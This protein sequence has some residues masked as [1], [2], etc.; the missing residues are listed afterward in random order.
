MEKLDML[1][2]RVGRKPERI[3]LDNTLEALNKAV[4]GHL[5]VFF[6][7]Y[8]DRVVFIMN[9]EGKYNGSLPNR[10]I[11][12][13]RGYNPDV[14]FGDFLVSGFDGEEFASL[15]DDMMDKYERIFS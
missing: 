13:E 8:N 9:E 4:D 14:I 3:K 2:I 5:Q 11:Y 7:S 12:D 15:P 1:Y 6:P 10:R